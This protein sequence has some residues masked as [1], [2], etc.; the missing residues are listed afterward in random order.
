MRFPRAN[1]K[2]VPEGGKYSEHKEAK[3]RVKYKDKMR[4]ALGVAQIKQDDGTIEGRRCPII[5]YTGR[6]IVSAKEEN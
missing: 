4:F 3:M 6:I 2:V 5:D 1:G